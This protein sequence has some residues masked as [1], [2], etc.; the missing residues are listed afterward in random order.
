MDG[1]AKNLREAAEQKREEDYQNYLAMAEIAIE[2]NI[3]NL[4][5]E[6][7]EK[8]IALQDYKDSA[9]MVQNLQE[10][11]D[12]INAAIAEK[13]RKAEEE[14]RY[15]QEVREAYGRE[16]PMAL[17]RP[18]VEQELNH[19]ETQIKELAADLK[20]RGFLLFS[21]VF[22]ILGMV[23]FIFGL[24]GDE[25]LLI[26]GGLCGFGF[27]IATIAQLIHR[28]KLR[29]QLRECQGKVAP[30]QKK[31]EDI[32]GCM[33]FGEFAR[34][35]KLRQ[36]EEGRAQLEEEENQRKLREERARVEA[37][38]AKR[39]K[40]IKRLVIT[41]VILLLIAGA[42][43]AGWY[44]MFHYLP[45][46][47]VKAVED[48]IAAGNYQAAYDA[49]HNLDYG[50]SQELKDQIA[51][52]GKYAVTGVVVDYDSYKA[53]D[54]HYW[55]TYNEHGLPSAFYSE[56][57]NGQTQ[58]PADLKPLHKFEYN[59]YESGNL[60]TCSVFTN[61][62]L[63]FGAVAA[64]EG[65]IWLPYYL[66]NEITFF[67]TPEATVV[68]QQGSGHATGF[69]W[70]S[71][72]KIPEM[73]CWD[74]QRIQRFIMETGEV[75]ETT[76]YQENGLPVG[77]E[78]E[79]D[80]Q[81]R[82]VRYYWPD[83]ELECR[84]TYNE[85]GTTDSEK[86]GFVPDDQEPTYL[87]TCFYDY[88]YENGNL[89]DW[90]VY[91]TSDKKDAD[92]KEFYTYDEFGKLL[93][94]TLYQKDGYG[95]DKIGEYTFTY[96]WLDYDALA[97]EAEQQR[98]EELR[99]QEE[100]RRKAQEELDRKKNAYAAAEDLEAQGR[101]AEAAVAFGKLAGFMDAEERC[102]ALWRQQGVQTFAAAR[103]HI[104]MLKN[105]GSVD[106]TGAKDDGRCDVSDWTGVVSV[107]GINGQTFG[108]RLD[109]TV[110]AT[111]YNEN[112]QCDVED[113][114]DIV[115]ISASPFHTV[116]LRSDG[117]VVATGYNE[118][119]QCEVWDWTD[120]VAISANEYHTVG[121]RSDGTVV[122]AGYADNGMCDVSEWT[123]ITA[124]CT[125][126]SNTYGLRS[127]GTVVAVGENNLWQCEVG[128]WTDIVAISAD[129]GYVVGL[130]SDG[131]VV[132][133]G[134]NDYDQCSVYYWTDIVAVATRNS[135]VV[136]LRSDGT[137]IARGYNGN[138]QCEIDT[139]TDVV[140]ISVSEFETVGLTADGRIL[141]ASRYTE[142]Y[143]F[144][145][146][147]D[148]SIPENLIPNGSVVEEESDG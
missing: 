26:V 43:L 24:D 66:D 100:E 39:K 3:R 2:R 60:K 114:E 85:D 7:Q 136:G 129:T 20:N 106:A 103:A 126:S 82:I 123:D 33:S 76:D 120:I 74:A 55:I 113:W 62:F 118:F 23:E 49:L 141:V 132:A 101:T 89:T 116:G 37:K 90:A 42:A 128:Y 4:L 130:R 44:Y 46:Q 45:G 52:K 99:Q 110:L 115:A 138:G 57:E 53:D 140:A 73:R 8:L 81:G 83:S 5:T 51:L 147:N 108:L 104:V 125:S 32:N 148:V 68:Y 88:H 31:L 119:G 144:E 70:S 145:K 84:M 137:V 105:D 109:G 61:R 54:Y 21:V 91:P 87:S 122:A 97:A 92:Q 117:T 56:E 14:K 131:T 134:N 65:Q 48:L 59:F 67:D 72:D 12:A 79:E 94:V 93:T 36:T 30:L 80:D 102:R 18:Q 127:D 63:T 16:V 17:E 98:Q 69:R 10:K 142:D 15:A 96:T 47:Q 34:T 121:L 28:A 41:T 27:G 13:R 133:E 64:P 111:G 75:A 22:F 146:F 95:L 11:I 6:A 124:V 139:W 1:E 38:R 50:N 25:T 40:L 9:Q 35:Y 77:T 19:L 29:R 86:F 143:N 112:G 135:H 107:A 78:W 58:L 71:I